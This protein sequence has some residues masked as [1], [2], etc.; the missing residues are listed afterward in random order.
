MN[1]G[2]GTHGLV[3]LLWKVAFL[4]LCALAALLP[5]SADQAAPAPEIHV[6]VFLSSTCPHC[7][8][9]EEDSLRALSARLACNIVPHYYDVDDMAQYK[10]L[11]VLERRL[12][13]AGNELPV[14]VLGPHV[15]GGTDEIE[16]GLEALLIQYRP[17][18]SPPVAVPTAQEAAEELGGGAGAPAEGTLHLAYFEQAGCRDCER[19]ERMLELLAAAHPMIYLERFGVRTPGGRVLLEALCERAGVPE[20]RRLLVPAVFLG[21]KGLVREEITDTSLERLLSEAD[22]AGAANTWDITAA[23]RRAARERLWKRAS[24]VTL[25]A[26]LVGGLVDGVNPCAFA[27]IV[28]LVCCLAGVGQDR[29]V[30]LAVGACFALGVFV[31][32]YVMGLG[33]SE[34]LLRLQGFPRVASAVS[35]AIIA[36]VFVLGALS[37]WDFVLALRGRAGQMALKL[38]HRLRMRINSLIA[39]RLRARWLA[40]AAFG[41]GVSVSLL[42]L[43]CTGQVYLPLIGMMTSVAGSRMRALAL[44]FLYDAAFIAPLLVVFGAVYLGLSSGRLLDTFKRRVA[45]GKLLLGAF[46]LSLGAVLIGLQARGMF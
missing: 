13:E 8:I 37:L 20:G 24:G 19:V 15:L 17:L 26:V 6:H 32:Y 38:P 22:P 44:L 42:E 9:V 40:P 5:A 39:R 10:R 3:D 14:L 2:C 29:R 16:G 12:G 45:L 34:A 30:I 35:W 46:F 1:L 4:C 41:L 28:F 21:S 23:E 43:V 11:V 33:L 25:A 27:T 18:G 7:E 31:A 36:L